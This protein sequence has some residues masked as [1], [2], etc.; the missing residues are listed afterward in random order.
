M[1]SKVALDKVIKKSRVHFYKPI[2]IAEILYRDRTNNRI[3]LLDL[4]SYRNSSKKWRDQITQ[5]LIGRISTS[6]QKY[7]DNIFE[8]NAMPPKLLKEL[9]DFNREN[10]G[11]VEAYIYKSLQQKLN[12]VYEVEN[13]IK[14]STPDTFN[15]KELLKFFIS[16]PGLKRSID[17]MY[18]IVVYALFSTIVRAL[19]TEVVMEIG[20]KDEEV[21]RD[22]QKFIKMVLGLDVDMQ[23][24][25]KPASL[26]RVGVT[27][28]ADRGLDMLSNFGPVIQVKHLTLT[29]ELAEDITTGIAADSIIIVCIDAEKEAINTLLTQIGIENRIQGII[30]LNDLNEWYG[31]CLSE[32]YHSTLGQTLLSDLHREFELEFPSSQAIEPF[33]QERDYQKI[34]LPSGWDTVSV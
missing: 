30:T 3:D 2:Q 27:N 24:V 15:L 21:L 32:K 16:N 5:K 19:Q 25:S 28:A 23:K 20:N 12:I 6:S 17:K 26:F 1:N 22:F 34:N 29:P 14:Q 7:Q 18:E 9:A 8:D 13:Y 33:F 31:L 11:V 10:N 4:E